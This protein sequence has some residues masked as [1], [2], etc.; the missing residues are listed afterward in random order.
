[1]FSFYKEAWLSKIQFQQVVSVGLATF[2]VNFGIPSEIGSF[3]D[4]LRICGI[5]SVSLR[6]GILIT[7]DRR[8]FL[9]VVEV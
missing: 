8:M 1:M 4:L 2:L 5:C 6:C 3:T 7:V 9:M